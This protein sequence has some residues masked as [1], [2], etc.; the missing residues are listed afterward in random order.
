M[1]QHG[2][3]NQEG[4][5]TMRFM[6]I[7]VAGACISLSVL[8]QEEKAMRYEANWDS[9]KQYKV[10]EWYKDAKF[11]IFIHWGVYSAPAFGNE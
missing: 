11:G 7:I 5:H 6:T 4:E 8:A 3:C 2:V 10:P 1:A 9:L